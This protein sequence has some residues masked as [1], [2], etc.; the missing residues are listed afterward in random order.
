VEELKRL[1]QLK[2]SH[3]D[4]DVGD[5][6]DEADDADDVDDD[7]A[8]D[9]DAD[10]D[11][12]VD[13]V[14]TH[15]D[16][17][18]ADDPFRKRDFKNLAELP[19]MDQLRVQVFLDGEE[20]APGK[21]DGEIG[22]FTEKA[23]QRWMK[24]HGRSVDRDSLPT[25][26]ERARAAASEPTIAYA[27]IGADLEHVGKVAASIPEQARQSELP[28]SSLAEAVSERFHT[29]ISMLGRLNPG[30]DLTRIGVGSRL[31]VPRIRD[32]FDFSSNM[33]M[34]PSGPVANHIVI[35]WPERILEVRAKDDAL[36]A[37]FP[38][39]LGDSTKYV[40][41]G[42]WRIGSFAP[43]PSF[44]WDASVL[45]SG[46]RSDRYHI[47]PPGPNNLVGV[48]WMGLK[49]PDG[50]SSPIGI[51]GT[52]QPE[53]IGRAQ[54]AGCIRLANWDVVRLSRLIGHNA[55]VRWSRI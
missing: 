35:V 25:L 5:A 55:S 20:F 40:R 48:L 10:D 23:A 7:N 51:H 41:S 14:D 30:V 45:K 33:P 17:E 38:V 42:T 47:L 36:V 24:A 12:A 28:Y 49:K 22:E 37:S 53:T 54:S 16:A 8:D 11:G 52:N 34:A 3:T 19:Y 26:I 27:V 9:D 43:L 13:D 50:S 18:D 1:L 46:I 32:P 6:H 2:R 15:Y 39:T 29:D 21:I 31:I 44:R 4:E